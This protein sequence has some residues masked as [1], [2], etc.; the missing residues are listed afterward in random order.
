MATLTC[1]TGLPLAEGGVGGG[2][3]GGNGDGCVGHSR[4]HRLVWHR[5]PISHRGC[6]GD[7]CCFT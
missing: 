1:R 2:E 6:V 7:A 4:R 3:G 5:Q